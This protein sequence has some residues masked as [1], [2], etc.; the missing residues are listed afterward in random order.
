MPSYDAVRA[1]HRVVPGDIAT[2]YLAT[3]HADFIRAW[4]G[5]VAVRPLFAARG[6]G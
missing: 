2:V 5:S 6:V 1:K 3:R 4:R